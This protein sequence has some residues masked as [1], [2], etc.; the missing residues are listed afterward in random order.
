MAGVYARG[1]ERTLRDAKGR[2]TKTGFYGCH[3]M[4]KASLTDQPTISKKEAAIFFNV[5]KNVYLRRW[6]DHDRFYI[7]HVRTTKGLR[8]LLTDV[9][10]QAFPKAD[11]HTIHVIAY[12]YLQ[13]VHQRR[14]A[15][16]RAGKEN[17][18]EGSSES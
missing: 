18:D 14:I 2:I 15:N 8:L 9:I 13:D 6:E 17:N 4:A 10:K 16:H 3:A 12:M 5:G 7:R 1:R 11:R